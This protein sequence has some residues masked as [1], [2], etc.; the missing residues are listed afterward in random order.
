MP[1]ITQPLSLGRR[2]KGWPTNLGKPTGKKKKSQGK[3]NGG[4]GDRLEDIHD[5]LICLLERLR[6]CMKRVD[7]KALQDKV[8]ERYYRKHCA[9]HERIRRC[10]LRCLQSQRQLGERLDE[11]NDHLT[12]ILVK[13]DPNF[14]RLEKFHD[15][16]GDEGIF[17]LVDDSITKS[18]TLES[19]LSPLLADDT[20]KEDLEA[21]EGDEEKTD[22]RSSMIRESATQTLRQMNDPQIDI[23]LMGAEPGATSTPKTTP[24][25]PRSSQRSNPDPSLI[26]DEPLKLEENTLKADEEEE[27]ER[28]GTHD[29][30]QSS[31]AGD[32]RLVSKRYS[33][34]RGM[35]SDKGEPYLNLPDTNDNHGLQFSTLPRAEDDFSPSSWQE[36]SDMSSCR[37]VSISAESA[38]CLLPGWAKDL[39]KN[40]KNEDNEEESETEEELRNDDRRTL[41]SAKLEKRQ[42]LVEAILQADSQRLEEILSTLL[43]PSM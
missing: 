27:G 43:K 22:K 16:T 23:L 37:P 26:P 14:T 7:E 3:L 41:S 15:F 4:I 31:S 2:L 19:N 12:G 34:L 13:S 6:H 20:D 39:L 17:E 30:N 42:I 18:F 1:L 35:K 29:Q 8:I 40:S 33:L 11:Q 25:K 28:P 21:E 24:P 38:N 10:L 32:P 5:E 36:I 9:A